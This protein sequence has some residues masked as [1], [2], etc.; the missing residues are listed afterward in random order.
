M[1]QHHIVGSEADRPGPHVHIRVQPPRRRISW[2]VVRWHLYA[3]GAGVFAVPLEALTGLP[4]AAAAIVS[5]LIYM[6]ASGR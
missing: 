4:I 2:R 5:A 3:A 6:L 1:T